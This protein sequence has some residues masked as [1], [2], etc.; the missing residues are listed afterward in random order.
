MAN[1][2]LVAKTAGKGIIPA[3]VKKMASKG[4][5]QGMGGKIRRCGSLLGETGLWYLLNSDGTYHEFVERQK[6]EDG[7]APYNLENKL[8]CVSDLFSDKTTIRKC[9]SAMADCIEKS[10]E[11]VLSATL[12]DINADSNP[13]GLTADGR[14]IIPAYLTAAIASKETTGSYYYSPSDVARI[15]FLDAIALDIDPVTGK[16]HLSKDETKILY[17]TLMDGSRDVTEF[18]AFDWAKPLLDLTGFLRMMELRATLD[19]Q[20]YPRFDAER[21]VLESEIGISEES[22]AEIAPSARSYQANGNAGNYGYESDLE[23]DNSPQEL[24]FNR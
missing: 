2:V 5:A 1:I 14:V 9:L 4:A 19:N 12:D 18:G 15:S 16:G 21:S 22:E 24:F 17:E 13:Y 7:N 20:I 23:L 8:R 11:R 10:D 6:S 3:A